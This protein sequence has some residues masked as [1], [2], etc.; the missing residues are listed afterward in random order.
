MSMGGMSSGSGVPSYIYMQQMYW[1]V[2][3]AAIAFATLVNIVNNILYRQRYI[4]LGHN[5]VSCADR[6]FK[7]CR[8]QSRPDHCR[9]AKKI[10]LL[11]ICNS[12]CHHS[13][14]DI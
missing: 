10:L 3:G 12:L 8:I 1:A 2:V 6:F 7:A 4:R 14:S 11:F 13:R 5:T 9:K